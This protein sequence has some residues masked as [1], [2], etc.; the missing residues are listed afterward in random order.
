MMTEMPRI[1]DAPKPTA[2]SLSDAKTISI[3]RV[4]NKALEE[5]QDLLQAEIDLLG[6]VLVDLRND[7]RMNERK[8]YA[9]LKT[10]NIMILQA[11]QDNETIRI[12][13]K[14]LFA[15]SELINT[16]SFEEEE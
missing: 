6:E 11:A 4:D 16:M 10:Q 5:G 3:L 8:I 1:D 12:L 2:V 15:G 14:L 13:R 9:M 7:K